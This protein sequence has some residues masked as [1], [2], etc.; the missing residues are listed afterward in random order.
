M[1][2]HS[3]TTLDVAL[4]LVI[5]AGLMIAISV[6]VS[7]GRSKTKAEFLLAN[8]SVGTVAGAMCVAAS[9]IWAPA[10]F[11][12]S[13]KAYEQGVAGIFWYVVPNVFTLIIFGPF[14]ARLRTL[15]PDGYTL[16]QYILYRHGL[17][18]H[19]IYIAQFFLLQIGSLA[20]QILAGSR[21]LHIAAGL[22]PAMA[23]L[24]LGSIVLTYALIGGLRASIVTDYIQMIAMLTIC[25]ITVP[26]AI[27]NAGG[28]SE[29]INGAGGMT[30]NFS[31]PLN[32]WVAYSFGLSVTVNLLAAPLGD[33]M[34][35]QRAYALKQKGIVRRVFTLGALIYAIVPISLSS[36]G[37]A[38]ASH[39]QAG[40]WHIAE[41]QMVGPTVVSML[42]PHFIVC[43]Y[44][45]M[46]VAGLCSTFDSS[47]CAV[48]SLVATD[49]F[50]SGV[51]S[52]EN[53]T[54]QEKGKAVL[55]SRMGMIGA[56]LAAWGIAQI[57]RLEII[58]LFLTYGTIRAATMVPTVMTLI[59]PK[60]IMP[61][62][63]G[64]ILAAV[65]VG[66]PLM[67]YGQIAG[68][69]NL[70]VIGSISTVSIS[71]ISVLGSRR[72]EGEVAKREIY[73]Q[74]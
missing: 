44:V 49:V 45:F 15:L 26:W 60:H 25:G 39:N 73:G 23:G 12:S 28:V 9:W 19:K 57:P 22:S 50:P 2:S 71:A 46:L 42:L 64:G 5:Y 21:L 41:P 65:A 7:R 58:H 43:V 33:Q 36:L 47:L 52:A 4:I 61:Y 37:F 32:P 8:R 48:A 31:N 53:S 59:R 55:V 18:A 69:L 24:C 34:Q 6:L 38:A 68:N 62:L 35:W 74:N 29:I 10:L 63:S 1:F 30:G 67:I 66:A 54:K 51:G 16:P 72:N 14:A 13:Q 17:Y 20:V 11:V 3:L 27:A 56:A 40:E 70:S